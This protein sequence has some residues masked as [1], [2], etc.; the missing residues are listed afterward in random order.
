MLTCLNFIFLPYV[1][2]LL[3]SRLSLCPSP[4]LP[5]FLPF[6]PLLALLPVCQCYL[7][8]SWHLHLPLF[9][10]LAPCLSLA[11]L[12]PLTFLPFPHITLLFCP[13]RCWHHSLLSVCPPPSILPPFLSPSLPSPSPGCFSR[14]LHSL[15]AFIPAPLPACLPRPAAPP[16]SLACLCFLRCSTLPG[17]LQ[18]EIMIIH[19]FCLLF[20]FPCDFSSRHVTCSLGILASVQLGVRSCRVL[21]EPVFLLSGSLPLKI[22]HEIESEKKVP[23]IKVLR[24]CLPMHCLPLAT[25]SSCPS[26]L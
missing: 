24:K 3:I 25:L 5:V 12:L 23:G 11:P 19:I 10:R 17:F 26:T 7:P 8:L 22:L 2:N 1:G 13:T 18:G 9:A 21:Y 15:R 14:L 16:P 6:P 4:S 20:L